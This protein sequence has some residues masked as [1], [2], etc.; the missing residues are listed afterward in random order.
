MSRSPAIAHN[1]TGLVVMVHLLYAHFVILLLH[2][3]GLYNFAMFCNFIL[4]LQENKNRIHSR[5]KDAGYLKI[6][7]FIFVMYR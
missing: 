1:W 3:C 4:A 6:L 2:Y 7:R 5:K